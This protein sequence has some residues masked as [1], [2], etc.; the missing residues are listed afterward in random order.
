MVATVRSVIDSGY[1]TRGDRLLMPKPLT[2]IDIADALE[3][4]IRKGTYKPG[5]KLPTHQE[6]GVKFGVGYTTVAKAVALLKDR[7][8]VYS[9]PPLGVFVEQRD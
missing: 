8:L 3:A 5:D 1:P 4:A 6:L 2:Y 9:A 7:G